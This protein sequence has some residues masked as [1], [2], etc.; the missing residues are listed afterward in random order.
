MK[1]TLFCLTMI[2]LL[3]GLVFATPAL[4]DPATDKNIQEICKAQPTAS[5][6]PDLQ[7][8][9]SEG[10]FTTILQNI[11]NALLFAAG[12][13]TVIMIVVSGIR[14]V[15]GRGNPDAV[16]KARNTLL[17]SIVGLVVAVSAW[18]IVNFVFNRLT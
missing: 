1:K 12:I 5:I 16:T 7:T 15:V 6:C 13:I 2:G 10:A 18:A 11:I 17:Y 3:G 8:S 9:D 4:A 14:F